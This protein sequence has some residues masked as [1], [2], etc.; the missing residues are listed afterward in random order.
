MAWAVRG[1]VCGERR[2]LTVGRDERVGERRLAMIH[3][4][5]HC[6]VSYLEQGQGALSVSA[7]VQWC[8]AGEEGGL[9]SRGCVA[10]KMR[11]EE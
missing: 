7:G 3:V 9:V 1:E 10:P 11:A 2:G 5:Q 4:R 8:R 6:E